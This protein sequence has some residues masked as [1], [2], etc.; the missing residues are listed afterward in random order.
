[1]RRIL[2][3]LASLL[4]S[5]IGTANAAMPIEIISTAPDTAGARFVFALKERIRSTNSLELTFDQSKP[6][7]QALIVTLDPSNGN[8]GQTT[9]YSVVLTWKN[10]VEPFS[11]YLTSYVGIS[12]SANLEAAADSIAAGIS[13]ESDKIL[14]ALQNASP[15]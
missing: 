12:G 8:Y 14:S 6:R 5:F 9:A 2:F 4:F 11:F 1:M 13:D 7:M 3:L 15:H 10:P